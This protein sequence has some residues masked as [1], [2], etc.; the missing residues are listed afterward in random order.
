[1]GSPD[2][3]FPE[4]PE[5]RND[6]PLPPLPECGDQTPNVDSP[7]PLPTPLRRRPDPSSCR[8]AA[9]AERAAFRLVNSIQWCLK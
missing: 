6:L 1:M 7:L 5:V 9:T 4:A 2:C 8:E 3:G